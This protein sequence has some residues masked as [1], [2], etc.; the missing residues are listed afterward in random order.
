MVIDAIKYNRKG[1]N[2]H[3]HT[4]TYRN[5]STRKLKFK[6]TMAV[7]KV[8]IVLHSSNTKVPKIWQTSVENES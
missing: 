7:K 4:Y 1:K 6:N 2:P 3:S 5:L 8:A